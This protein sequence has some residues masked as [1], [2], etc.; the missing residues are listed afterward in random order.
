MTQD[1]AQYAPKQGPQPRTTE[2]PPTVFETA[3]FDRSATP[4]RGVDRVSLDGQFKPAKELGSAEPRRRFRDGGLDADAAIGDAIEIM[5]RKAETLR[6][7]DTR[8]YLAAIATNLFRRAYNQQ[9][10]CS[11]NDRDEVADES[12]VDEALRTE[13]FKSVKGLV[14]RW[15][16]RAPP[17]D[18]ACRTQ[19]D[20]PRRA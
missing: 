15:G 20:V 10:M 5:V 14:G 3:A 13:I 18:D 16:E 19:R 7:E 4:P 9:R 6:V 1:L 2:R 17:C 12:V 11:F 8:A